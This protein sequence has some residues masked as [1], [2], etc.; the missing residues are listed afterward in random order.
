MS[1]L[2]GGPLYRFMPQWNATIYSAIK[3]IFS[4]VLSFNLYGGRTVKIVL[5][6]Q[7]YIYVHIQTLKMTNNFSK[8]EKKRT[9]H[10]RG[11]FLFDFCLYIENHSV[12]IGCIC[13]WHIYLFPLF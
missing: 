2:A 8:R 7:Q 9:Q 4:L 1:L 10:I 12:R 6:R 3:Q 13:T 11:G 5:K